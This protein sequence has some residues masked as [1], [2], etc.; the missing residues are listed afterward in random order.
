MGGMNTFRPLPIV[1]FVVLAC[2]LGWLCALPLWLG[3]GLHHPHFTAIGGAIMWTPA[4]A[5][6]VVSRWSEPSV[7][8]AVALGLRP[9][10]PLGRT[11]AFCALAMLLALATTLAA[12]AVGAALGVYRFD[13]H[14]FSGLQE[15]L[16]QQLAGRAA[17]APALPPL[18]LLAAMNVL[19]VTLA[20]PLAAAL[21]LGEEIGWRGWLLPRLMPLGTGPALLGSGIVWGLWHAPLIL[22][23]YNYG[24]TPGAVAL[25]CMSAMCIVVGAVLAWLRLRSGSVWPAALGHA[26][27]NTSAALVMVLGASG[28]HLDMTRATTLGWTGWLFPA[29]LAAAL[30]LLCKPHGQAA[31][32]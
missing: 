5:A 3:S 21:T 26:A 1:C 30:F 16:A 2:A 24:A 17:A 13:L 6:A 28:Q 27:L 7:P 11:L 23:G 18:P 14:S 8:L 20:A 12:L 9:W 25:A 22:L 31:H 10:R 4:L 15:L 32:V 29:A 19:S